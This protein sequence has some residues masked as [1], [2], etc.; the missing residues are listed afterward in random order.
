MEEKRITVDGV[1]Y[2]LPDP[3]TEIATQNPIGSAG[4]HNLPDSQL[5]R[6]MIKLSMGYPSAADEAMILNSKHSENPLDKV[7]AVANK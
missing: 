5:D 1:T 7:S 2:K 3:Y 6:F 4:T